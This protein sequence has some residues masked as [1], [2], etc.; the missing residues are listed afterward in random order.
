VTVVAEDA[1]T[2][3]RLAAEAVA[4][5]RHWDD[6]LTTWRPEGELARFNASAGKGSVPLGTDLARALDRM[7][8]LSNAT[9][10]AFDPA[11]GPLVRFWRDAEPRRKKEPPRPT[12]LRDALSIEEGRASLAPGAALDAGAIGKGIAL[13]TVVSL[14]R[15][16]GAHAAFLDFGGSSQTAFGARA[17]GP[18][19]WDVAVAG[20]R[21]GSVHGVVRLRE[22]SLSTS[23]A[24][25]AG[26]PAGSIVDPR[27]GRPVEPGRLAT[28]LA[29]D[30][31]AA[32]AWSTALVVLGRPGLARIEA[33]G[34]EALY[35]DTEGVARTRGF[36]LRPV[37]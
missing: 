11:V 31:T 29:P 23:R 9:G 34:L 37:R 8:A 4:T 36:S 20:L 17:E 28:V 35:E 18:E 21:P 12:R 15:D 3:R 1:A 2:A 10:G 24:Q 6:V 27:S 19:G 32:D 13:D 7:L 14:L 5:A 30:A 22:R 33:A 25:A 16:G 26:D